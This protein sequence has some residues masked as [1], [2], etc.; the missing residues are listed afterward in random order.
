[1]NTKTNKNNEYSILVADDNPDNVRVLKGVLEGV[2][3][4]VRVSTNGKHVLASV[5]QLPPDLVLLDIHMPEMD[6][7]ETCKHLKA[8]EA[9]KG[10]PVI[11]LSALTEVFNKVEAFKI[12]AIDYIEKPFHASEV[13][14]RV[15]THIRVRQQFKEIEAFNDIMV[16]REMQLIELKKEINHLSEALGRKV[17]YEPFWEK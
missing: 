9:S 6:G 11:F 8:S 15:E 1:M 2:G 13:L 17:P 5:K 12:G 3:Y 10:I 7:Y 14:M 16:D 4:E